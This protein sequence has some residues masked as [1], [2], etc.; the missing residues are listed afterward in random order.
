[1]IALDEGQER[2]ESDIGSLS[3][4]VYDR[5]EPDELDI[6]TEDTI[7]LT[8]APHLL[9]FEVA[10]FTNPTERK[11]VLSIADTCAAGERQL[12]TRS[13]QRSLSCPPR[14]PRRLA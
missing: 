14:S 10:V 6:A 13:D 5:A 11:C 9:N 2:L 7:D 3:D 1:M 4:E 12:W 8:A